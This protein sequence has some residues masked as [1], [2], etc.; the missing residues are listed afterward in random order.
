MQKNRILVKTIL[1]FLI[2]GVY[3]GFVRA[4]LK[5][6]DRPMWIFPGQIFRVALEQPLG[7]GELR[8]EVPATLEMFDRWPK[9]TIQRFYFRARKPGNATLR[10]QGKAGK[11]E[12]PLEVLAWKEVFSPREHH[13]IRLPRIWPLDDPSCREIKS[14]RTLHTEEEYNVLK[15][16]SPGALAKQWAELTDEEVFNITI[17]HV[18]DFTS[19]IPIHP[20][21]TKI[22]TLR[23]SWNNC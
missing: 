19:E 13:E 18:L 23:Y 8:V 22:R 21:S 1:P 4:E 7:S 2:M 10:F 14:R 3:S 12:L 11:L 9:D 17:N 16:R 6:L 20:F 15:E 5:L